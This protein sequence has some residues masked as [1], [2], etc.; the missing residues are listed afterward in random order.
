MPTGSDGDE[1][2]LLEELE[3]EAEEPARGAAPPPTLPALPAAATADGPAFEEAAADDAR[4]DVALYEAEA[5]G[6]PRGPTRA[7]LWLEVARL[8]ETALG[9]GEAALRAARAAFAA[10]PSFIVAL[11]PLRR[12][13]AARAAWDELAAAYE[14]ALAASALAPE[15]RADLLVERGRLLE[16]RLERAADARASYVAALAAAPDHAPALLALF[17]SGARDNEATALEPALAGLARRSSTPARRVALAVSLAQLLR[18]SEVEG[19]AA[20]A[21][22]VVR[23]A[24]R[25]RAQDT[26]VAPLLAELDALSR[27]A[28]QPAVQARALQEL[29]HEGGLDAAWVAALLRERARLQRDR[30]GDPKG[31]LEALE[32]A[33]R[34]A[35]G[36][37][38]IAAELIDLAAEL[39]RFDVIE[40]VVA[41]FEAAAGR[42]V[43]RVQALAL[44][45]VTALGR[46]GRLA[47]AVA[48]LD[49]SP[50]LKRAAGQPAVFGLRVAL[51]AR[52][53]DARGLVEAFAAEGARAGGAAGARA[54]VFAATVRQWWADDPA[55]AED[56]YRRA[57]AA[58]PGERAA[59][60]A[61]E[62]LLAAQGR[63]A[64]LADLL[65]AA[66]SEIV[67]APGVDM[68]ERELTLRE[69]LVALY[70]DD[71]HAPHKAF[72][73]QKQ[74]VATAPRDVRQRVRLH[75]L[76]LAGGIEASDLAEATAEEVESLRVLAERADAAA[77]AASLKV[78]AARLLGLAG[79]DP[80][81]RAAA[82]RLLREAAPD[83]VT[84]LAT[85][86]L[87][88][89]Q[90]DRASRAALVSAELEGVTDEVP[91]EIVRALRFRLAH[92]HAASGR[93]AEAVAALTPLRAEQD[94]L[95]RAWSWELARRSGDA[96]LEVAVLSDEADAPRGELGAPADVEIALGEALERAG[97]AQGAGAAFSRALALAPSADAALGLLRVAATTPARPEAT[98]AALAA[99]AAAC[100]D[101]PR[102]AAAAGREEALLRVA[103][104]A[105]GDADLTA[106]APASATA[107][108]RAEAAIVRWAA[109]VTRGDAGVVAG[110]LYELGATM[111]AAGGEGARDAV[112]LLARASARARLAGRASSEALHKRIWRASHAPRLAAA[113]ADLPVAPGDGW[114]SD[115]P[116]PRRA[117]RRMPSQAS[118]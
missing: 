65:E 94:P 56:L 1:E 19:G 16:D 12:L 22:R 43:E 103:S 3:P 67:G 44:R 100:G 42:N 118:R 5:A 29:A 11:G 112:P 32:G 82:E 107:V 38:L 102:V 48:A 76:E 115:R 68:A 51:L 90:V 73:H 110:A 59:W 99:V 23:D 109:G 111:A 86:L 78:E 33:A 113:V 106:V 28:R 70:R 30:L 49:A 57:I 25:E 63:W 60:D 62:S 7:S 61:L 15:D 9:D 93:Y 81:R 47:E 91:S 8:E 88:A 64:E 14:A 52:A 45:Q 97:D 34:L 79:E 58:A 69:E 26:P 27:T 96:I 75:D 54:L 71:L 85:A 36:H 98:S 46:A 41:R 39:D 40:R 80:A 35:P 17:L 114:P 108:E 66:L 89:S 4:A 117:T 13:L 6:E 95:A 31:A 116:D 55:G 10:A 101:E 20:R 92:H 21:L 87:E 37:A 2:L 84:G 24:L 74:L 53:R 50:G 77:V 72:A 18:V 105:V 104:G 83:D